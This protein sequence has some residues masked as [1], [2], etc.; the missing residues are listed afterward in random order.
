MFALMLQHLRR[1]LL[2]LPPALCVLPGAQHICADMVE[3]RSGQ[4]IRGTVVRQTVNCVTIRPR[5]SDGKTR[6]LP[7][8]RIR[9]ITLEGRR[10]V[11]PSE[12]PHR[13]ATEKPTR[14]GEKR[15]FT[16]LTSHEY[17]K[18]FQ[19]YTASGYR[20]VD[21]RGYS[22]DGEA[23]YDLT[24]RKFEAGPYTT[25]H[26][27]SH[28]EF[29]RA[30]RSARE[31]A[32]TLTVHSQFRVSGKVVHAAVWET[33]PARFHRSG[34]IPRTG[35]A[36]SALAPVDKGLARFVR[37]H[38]IPGAAVAIA[39]DGR[40]LYARGFGYAD[41][42]AEQPVRPDSLFR[43]ASVSKPITAAAVMRLVERDKLSLDDRAVDILSDCV[44]SDGQLDP[45][46]KRVTIEQL[47][48]HTAGWDSEK[49]MDPMFATVRIA[50]DLGVRPPAAPEQ[51]VR[52]MFDR[53]LD[54]EPGSKHAYSNFGYCILGRIIEQVTGQ[55][56]EEYVRDSVLGPLG[57][58]RMKI[59]RSRLSERV[60]D[61]VRYYAR[62]P[63]PG[64]SVFR[65]DAEETVPEQYGGWCLQS[66]DAHG[67]WIGSAIDL[68][69]F[70]SSFGDSA[71]KRVLSQ[72]SVRKMFAPPP[73]PIARG[74]EGKLKSTYYGYGWSV[75]PKQNGK[76]AWHNGAFT[77][78]SALLVRRH[79]GFCW[80]VL[81]NTRNSVRGGTAANMVDRTMHRLMGKVK[82][83]PEGQPLDR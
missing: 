80:A 18:R 20:P 82:D 23:R 8:P 61:E 17:Q 67:G 57:I 7:A 75:R 77:G 5:K 60:E 21:I 53:P 47:L 81:F 4:Q 46:L 12:P 31:K 14:R 3:M 39:R 78:T 37:R 19:E 6:T 74:S 32:M 11:L 69:R 2:Y 55:S 58:T 59:G 10:R 50:K 63:R 48:H 52:Y 30:N 54:F 56:Y 1:L 36:T 44:P 51:I 73:A 34:E 70:A 13:W 25:R 15:A 76:N 43:I 65:P 16:G 27:C 35:D 79:D 26:G 38:D 72:Q 49:S 29:L 33:L 83:W 45:R 62:Y 24:M 41:L 42:S 9:A 22:E 66:M 71:E 64:P 28:A 40:L 68:V